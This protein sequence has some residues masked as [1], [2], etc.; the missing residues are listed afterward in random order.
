MSGDH[1]RI[2]LEVIENQR[3]H[4]I[5]SLAGKQAELEADERHRHRRDNRRPQHLAGVRT[6]SRGNING[7]HRQAAAIDLADGYFIRRAHRSG[8]ASAEQ[9]IHQ[10]A[11][12]G[13]LGVPG[14]DRNT[15]CL[16]LVPGQRRITRQRLG[17]PNRQDA[18]L[19]TCASRQGR[20]QV[21]I[22]GVVAATGQHRHFASLWP[23]ATQGP[24]GGMG[25][26]LH[27]FEAGGTRGDQAGIECAHLLGGIERQ[28]QIIDRIGHA[29]R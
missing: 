24:P 3:P 21:A 20:Q 25:S 15:C 7:Q 19:P 13:L 18:H 27:Q 4:M 6:E 23:T 12:Q 16:G 26:P 10:H 9:R 5:R 29:I 8:E 2:R 22:P 28:R 1:F 17:L 14:N 11:A